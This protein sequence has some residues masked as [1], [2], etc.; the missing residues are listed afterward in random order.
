MESHLLFQRTMDNRMGHCITKNKQGMISKIFTL[1]LQLM[2]MNAAELHQ[3]MNS[4]GYLFEIVK[5]Q[6]LQ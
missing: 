6:V 4:V 3:I 5:L 2:K 1:F